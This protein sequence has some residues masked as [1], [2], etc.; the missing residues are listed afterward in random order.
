MEIKQLFIERL[1]PLFG[2]Q[3]AESMYKHYAIYLQSGK[4]LT[5]QEILHDIQALCDQV[6][7]QYVVG[8]TFFYANEFLV[9]PSVLIP[10]PE[11]EELV[12]MILENRATEQSSSILDIGTGSA[13]ILLSLLCELP[14]ARGLGID[15]S[16]SALEIAKQNAQQL[17]LSAA[18]M[19]LDILEELLWSQL[20]TYDIIVSNPPYIDVLE[21]DR[22]GESTL[23]YEP[24]I[25][26]FSKGDPDLFYKKIAAFGH[27]HLAE[28]GE[29]WCE[30]NEFRSVEIQ[31][32]FNKANFKTEVYQD[33]QSKDRVIKATR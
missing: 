33:M 12:R 19:A 3:E 7:I 32:I 16:E 15:I 9:N 27:K 1:S 25:A 21:E 8:K 26:L 20:N 24:E 17:K 5:A 10:R 30:M 13:C 22:M 23:K 11:T 6:P 18:F 29:I 14:A 2:D 31:R 4:V 28:G